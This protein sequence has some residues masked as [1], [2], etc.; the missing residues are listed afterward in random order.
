[1]QK[2]VKVFGE[3]N[4]ASR[5]VHTMIQTAPLLA[6]ASLHELD[7]DE[8]A[9]YD[10]IIEQICAMYTGPWRRVY[11]EAVKDLRDKEMGELARWKHA[12]PAYDP[13][14]KE[15]D[16]AVLFLVRNPYS[17]VQS[18]S[19]RPYHCLGRR[20]QNL[21]DFLVFPWLCVGRDNVEPIL[22]SP[23]QLW[24]LKLAAYRKF[25]ARAA[26][27]GVRSAVVRFEDFVQNPVF[28][29][30]RALHSIDVESGGLKAV[31]AATKPEYEY[32]MDRK[33]FY[34][35]ECWREDLT[36]SSVKF[37]NEMVDWSL[38]DSFG[39]TQLDPETFPNQDD[40]DR[41]RRATAAA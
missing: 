34:L 17:W 37:I 6:D 8:F 22:N 14:Y 3:R 20:Q 35:N 30:T 38:A 12:A 18:L 13:I 16:V 40:L 21:E 10:A 9:K 31:A 24:S 2:L 29:M 15:L 28:A 41:K 1:M 7:Q 4:T 33:T 32:G 36:S 19:R 25:Q 5:A 27:D 26:Q 39:Y 11:R 23:M